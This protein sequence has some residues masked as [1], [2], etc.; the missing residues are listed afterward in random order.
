MRKYLVMLLAVVSLS[1]S[2]EDPKYPVSAIPEELKA[3]ANAVIREEEESFIINSKSSATHR[4]HLVITILNAQG[5]DYAK[6]VIDYSKLKKVSYFKSYVYDAY[7]KQISKTKASE[8]YDQAAYDGNLFSDV[9]LKAVNLSQGSY[10]Y[11]VVFDYE[12]EFKFLFYIPPF[13]LSWG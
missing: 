1:A 12:I 5:S 4:V 10:P 9:R 6:K 11:T 3:D 13:Y 7:G 8:I 2:A